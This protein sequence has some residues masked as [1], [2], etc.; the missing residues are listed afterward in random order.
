NWRR[1]EEY[2]RM[3]VRGLPQA[4]PSL[5]T[6]AAQAR[7][8][9]GDT[10]GALA[11]YDLA[12][13]AGLTVGPKNLSS[14]ERQAYYAAGKLLGEAAQARGDV[15]AAIA[16]FHLYTEYEKSGIETL[17]ILSDL[18]EKNGDP[19]SAARTN[20]QALLYNAKD[21]DLLERKDR[22]YYSILPESL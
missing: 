8:R 15:E 16:H 6:Q 13:R 17:R 7:Q 9:A 11:D 14:E 4:G 22:Y 2:L 19:L 18:H 3:A 20:E 21:K 10:A 12:K 1:G 5:F